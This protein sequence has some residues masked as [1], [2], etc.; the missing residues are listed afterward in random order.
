MGQLYFLPQLSILF[1]FCFCHGPSVSFDVIG[2]I[3]SLVGNWTLELTNHVSLQ[4]LNIGL[5][6]AGK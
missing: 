4:V 3:G 1:L 2:W 6:L 5:W